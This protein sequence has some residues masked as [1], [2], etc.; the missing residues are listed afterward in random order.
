MKIVKYSQNNKK[1]WNT[2]IE[3]SKNG[4]FLFNRDFMDYHKDQFT[5]FSLMVYENEKLIACFP[6]NS[7]A[8]NQIIS[9]Q[10]LTY[11]GIVITT[12]LRLN[13]YLKIFREILHFLHHNFITTIYYKSIPCFYTTHPSEEENYALFLLKSENYRTDT[14]VT[15]QNNTTK[16]L[17]KKDRKARVKQGNKLNLTIENNKGFEAFWNQILI[18]NLKQK[19]NKK[20]VHSLKEIKLLSEKFPN[21]IHQINIFYNN[22]IVAGC[23]IFETKTTAHTQYIAGNT[24][25][26]KSGALD[27]LIDELITT[28]FAKKQYFDFGICNEKEGKYINHGLLDWKEG[29]GGRTYVHKFYKINTENFSNLDAVIK[30]HN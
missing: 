19:F 3:N 22:T 11:G 15:I 21:Q 5:D 23:T 25:G 18:P 10:G 9:H 4:T 17:Y 20:P 26:K 14:S 30:T 29:F 2:F 24:F 8:N 27:K 6:A 13:K 28:T 1:E 12:S 7:N 16:I